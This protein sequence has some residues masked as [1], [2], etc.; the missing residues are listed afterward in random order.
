MSKAS[1]WSDGD[2]LCQAKSDLLDRHGVVRHLPRAQPV[3]GLTEHAPV[4]VVAQSDGE[5][6]D[7]SPRLEEPLYAG[8]VQR[9]GRYSHGGA[10]LLVEAGH[11][12]RYERRANH[13]G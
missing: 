9:L 1:A 7:S 4:P 6:C 5:S 12:F 11:I 10:P 13:S 8:E 3:L 2:P